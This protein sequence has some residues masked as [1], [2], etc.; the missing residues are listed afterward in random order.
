MKIE[1][2][3]H[4]ELVTVCLIQNDT[5]MY[6]LLFFCLVFGGIIINIRENLGN[7]DKI[8][9]LTIIHVHAFPLWTDN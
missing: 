6:L 9:R 5:I 3:I 1:L 7:S 8:R 4:V 2:Y